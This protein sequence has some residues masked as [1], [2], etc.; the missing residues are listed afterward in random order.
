M[1]KFKFTQKEDKWNVPIFLKNEEILWL[2]KNGSL[3]SLKPIDFEQERLPIFNYKSFSFAAFQYSLGY[4]KR[5]LKSDLAKIDEITL[6]GLVQDLKQQIRVQRLIVLLH[7][8]KFLFRS[9]KLKPIFQQLLVQIFQQF[10][11][12]VLPHL[13]DDLQYLD[14]QTQK[15]LVAL[16]YP[17]AKWSNSSDWREG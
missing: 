17:H 16:A 8:V 1:G 15:S 10:K 3:C 6:F 11:G 14:V 7:Y 9:R 2:L 12:R 4:W 5:L 13:V